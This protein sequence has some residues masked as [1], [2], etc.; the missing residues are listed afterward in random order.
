MILDL[1]KAMVIAG[2]PIAL[3]SY[4]LVKLTQE[5]VK[6]K[7]NNAKQLQNE[8]KTLKIQKKKGDNFFKHA[9]QKKFMKFGAGFYG[10]VAFITYMHIE[11][12][13]V[14][15]FVQNYTDWQHFIDSIGFGM[16]VNFLIEAVMNLVTAFAWPIYWFKYLPIDSFWIWLLVAIF[17]HSAAVK[18][19]LSRTTP[20]SNKEESS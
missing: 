13:Q 19:A 2:V 20:I 17:A 12:Y 4:Y 3:F 16:L 9:M 5:K 8:L 7:A 6:L 1:F 18:Y 11:V 14:I 15:T 10:I